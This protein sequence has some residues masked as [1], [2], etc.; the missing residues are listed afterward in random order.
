[1]LIK[2]ISRLI[3]WAEAYKGSCQTSMMECF[4]KIEIILVSNSLGAVTIF[5]KRTMMFDRIVN[6][7]VLS[8]FMYLTLMQ[9]WLII[10]V[11]II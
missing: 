11:F 3:C 9:H 10:L 4:A 5:A 1:M 6:T 2:T 8:V 7:S